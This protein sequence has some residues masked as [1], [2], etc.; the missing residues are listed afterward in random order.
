MVDADALNITGL[1]TKI[2]KCDEHVFS[3]GERTITRAELKN[4]SN[5]AAPQSARNNEFEFA[6]P[7]LPSES[8]AEHRWM[9][10]YHVVSTM[11]YPIGFPFPR[12]LSIGSG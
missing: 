3:I 7:E 4:I 11:F 2:R 6:G 10:R 9:V 1:S 12:P 5:R 8:F